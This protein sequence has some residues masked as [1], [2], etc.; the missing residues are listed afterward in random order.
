MPTSLSYSASQ[1]PYLKN[2]SKSK[3]GKANNTAPLKK[4]KADTSAKPQHRIYFEDILIASKEQTSPSSPGWRLYLRW[5]GDVPYL[6]YDEYFQGPSA[7][8]TMGM[9]QRIG[10]PKNF[11]VGCSIEDFADRY[12]S[13]EPF[14][15][16]EYT[17]RFW[18]AIVNSKALRDFFDKANR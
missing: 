4:T 16:K 1:L 13:R 2:M 18:S 8:S 12:C 3:K 14:N 15:P 7:S 5:N 9:S 17:N 11:Y 10:L 6:L